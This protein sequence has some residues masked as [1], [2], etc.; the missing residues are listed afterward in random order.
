MRKSLLVL[1][2][3][4]LLLAG[5]S[6]CRADDNSPGAVNAVGFIPAPTLGVEAGINLANLNGQNVNDVIASRLGF[7]GGSNYARTPI[8]PSGCSSTARFDSCW[9][10]HGAPMR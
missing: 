5:S 1:T 4:S 8:R 10:A 6:V 7:V 3:L 2:C 9:A